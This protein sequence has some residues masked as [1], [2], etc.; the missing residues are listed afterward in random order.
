MREAGA[1]FTA[2]GQALGVHFVTVS[3]WWDRYQAGGLEALELSCPGFR[4]HHS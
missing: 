2:I 3:M 4:R 1:S